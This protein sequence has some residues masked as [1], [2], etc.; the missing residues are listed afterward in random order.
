MGLYL[1]VRD[2]SEEV[3]GV[4]VGSYADYGRFLDAVVKNVEGGTQ[5]STCPTL[6]LHSD[7][8][9]VWDAAS[10]IRLRD[11]LDMILRSFMT[12]PPIPLHEP[13]QL[14]VAKTF[15]IKPESLSDCFF[16]V[17]GEPLLG[18]LRALCDAA[19]ERGRPILFQ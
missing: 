5:G 14:N 1:C 18:R 17:D 6:T 10:C 4:E 9:G 13:W 16:D 2:E 8:E 7:C 11:E 19:I 12:A 15:G 3:E